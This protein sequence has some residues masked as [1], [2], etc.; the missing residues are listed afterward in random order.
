MKNR[1]VEK[2]TANRHD[3]KEI[4][5][6]YSPDQQNK[7]LFRQQTIT[8][9]ATFIKND[10]SIELSEPG[11]GWLWSDNS[12][13]IYADPED[14]LN[15][16]LDYLRFIF[17][18]IIG[19]KIIS[20]RETLTS[21][22]KK[23]LG[24]S[25]FY[26]NI[27]T[28]RVNNFI[29]DIYPFFYKQM[30]S[31]LENRLSFKNVAQT[32]ALIKLGHI[33]RFIMAGFEYFHNW[34]KKTIELD[35][36]LPQ[37]VIDVVNKT[38]DYSNEYGLHYPSKKEAITDKRLTSKY[39]S[40]SQNILK[41][42]IW[43][44]IQTLIQKDIN[45]QILQK[46]LQ[47]L[48]KNGFSSKL[49]ESLSNNQKNELGRVIE[50]IKKLSQNNKDTNYAAVR[51]NSLSLK[52]RNQLLKHISTLPKDLIQKLTE[53]AKQSLHNFEFELINIS[54]EQIE[55]K[56]NNEEIEES[57]DMDE[58]NIEPHQH[59]AS[60]NEHDNSADFYKKYRD[61]VLPLIEDLESNLWEIFS[62]RRSR[63]WKSKFKSGKR[64]GIQKRMQEKA[65]GVLAVESKAWLRRELPTEQDYAILVLNDCSGSMD[66][67]KIQNDLKG[68]IAITESINRLSINNAV[69]GFN[70]RIHRYKDFDEE[71][72]NKVRLGIISMLEEVRSERAK[73][74]DDGWA[75][76]E[77]SKYL[78][79]QKEAIKILIVISDGLPDESLPHSNQ[80]YELTKIVNG[81]VGTTNQKLIG[82]GIGPGTDH[83]EKYYPNSMANIG[84]DEMPG[85]LVNIIQEVIANHETF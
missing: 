18:Q 50:K 51:L 10:A 78:E 73:Y 79:K 30:Y 80:S 25:F 71:M 48:A 55:K 41:E 85:V 21:N 4:I 64:I 43:P 16:D 29:F 47:Y 24:F 33:P 34:Y 76:E 67:G 17:L 72:T 59:K 31:M 38:L 35:N 66:G 60:N 44:E 52:L 49:L 8:A 28:L 61:E 82:L 54:E 13:T 12:D 2:N 36:G 27:E 6:H 65:S 58:E 20:R 68:K 22:I 40:L 77:A 81:I 42:K 26:Y 1:G 19:Q 63:N 83:V 23:Q 75:L 70:D 56:E 5:N 9:L 7:I 69:W 14:L 37:E 39:A 11:T 62:E 32:K 15:Q 45:D 3:T 46:F 84:I 53:Q 74:N 57:G